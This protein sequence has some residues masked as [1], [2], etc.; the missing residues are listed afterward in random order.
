M[1]GHIDAIARQIV[2]EAF[3]QVHEEQA[4]KDAKDYWEKTR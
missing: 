1:N 4:R 2:G 3:A